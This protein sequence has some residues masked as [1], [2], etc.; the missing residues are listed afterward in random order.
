MNQGTYRPFVV[1]SWRRWYKAARCSHGGHFEDLHDLVHHHTYVG[2]SVSTHD[3]VVDH[4]V[5]TFDRGTVRKI[6]RFLQDTVF[7]SQDAAIWYRDDEEAPAGIPTQTARPAWNLG[8]DVRRPIFTEHQDSAIEDVR[9]PELSVMP[10][11]TLWKFE[12]VY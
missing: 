4:S 8:H 10:T 6:R 1:A 3:H 5:I 11:G 7:E 12:T 9:K 2:V